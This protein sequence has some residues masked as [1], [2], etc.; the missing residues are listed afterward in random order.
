METAARPPFTRPQDFYKLRDFGQKFEATIAFLRQYGGNL[1]RVLLPVLI[2]V[3]AALVLLAGSGVVGNFGKVNPN[4]EEARQT[5]TSPL[6]WIAVLMF[7]AAYLLLIALLYGFVKRRMENPDPLA[8]ISSAEVWADVRGRLL[9]LFAQTVLAY[10]CVMIGMV[11]LVIPGLYLGL[12]LLLLPAIVLFERGPE[13]SSFGLSRA[14][15]LIRG[16]WWSTC[17]LVVVGSMAAALV[18]VVV[19]GLVAL[20]LSL[21]GLDMASGTGLLTV[22]LVQNLVSF[23]LAPFTYLLL[24][25]QYF[26]LVERRD[27][28]SLQ[29][30]V[31]QLGRPASAAAPATDADGSLFRPS[32][33]D[34]TL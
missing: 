25:F 33:G 34:Q 23:A 13:A 5:L 27:G 7:V 32:Y 30:K 26:N 29:W 2:P 14:L 22:Q 12:A 20:L 17:G 16:K 9:P 28:V 15:S 31:E 3:L 4:D 6:L 19:S 21:G 8:V 11:L 18:A 1:A 24:L 10:I